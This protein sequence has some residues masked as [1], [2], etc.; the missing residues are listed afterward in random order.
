MVKYTQDPDFHNKFNASMKAVGVTC[1]D[2]STL[3]LMV[4][5]KRKSNLNYSISDRKV[6]TSPSTSFPYHHSTHT[7]HEVGKE[8]TSIPK[9]YMNDVS[10]YVGYL[11]DT[12]LRTFRVK[13]KDLKT[14]AETVKDIPYVHRW[15]NIYKNGFLAK[16]Y[17]LETHLDIQEACQGISSE[18]TMIT[19]TVRHTGRTVE[20]C[21]QLLKE[22]WK[23]L[24]DVLFRINGAVDYFRA[25]EPH[26]SGYP[27]MHVFYMMRFS[28]DL[29]TR[30][31]HLWNLKYELGTKRQGIHFR[32][33]RSSSDGSFSSGSISKMRG[34]VMKYVGKSLFPSPTD[35]DYDY[36]FGEKHVTLKLPPKQLLFNSILKKT[37]TRLW[38][39]S[40]NF[41]RVMARPKKDLSDW[42]CTEVTQM[43]GDETVSVLWTQEGGRFPKEVKKLKFLERC[44]RWSVKT[45]RTAFFLHTVE[46]KI[47]ERN[48]F[49]WEVKGI[50]TDLYIPFWYRPS[51]P[52][53]AGCIA[54]EDGDFV[55]VFEQV[56]VPVDLL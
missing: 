53:P 33:V 8:L 28:K 50:F 1:S 10:N 18:A 52:F 25:F 51:N 55:N 7:D 20:E 9:S 15:T 49:R 45:I 4:L 43:R 54:E 40:R 47:A 30:L 13:G 38:N 39:A 44:L 48:G 12:A 16:M 29:Q 6:K 22:K 41:S 42:Q 27:H 37:K 56:Y 26:K 3:D 2:P 14:G 23:K 31:R 5:K 11:A 17:Q 34:Y 19:L 32:E 24:H 46:E 36:I 35:P 21:L